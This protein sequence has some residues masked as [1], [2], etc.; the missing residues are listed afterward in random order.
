M[1]FGSE[2]LVGLKLIECGI[3]K[4]SLALL[5]IPQTPLRIFLPLVITKYTSGSRPFDILL[6]AYK[7][8]YFTFF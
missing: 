7:F 6:Q 3:R 2:S 4:E 1:A 5:S 8:R